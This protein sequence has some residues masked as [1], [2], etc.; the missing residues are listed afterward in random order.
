M[1]HKHKFI[2]AGFHYAEGGSSTPFSAIDVYRCRCGKS[3]DKESKIPRSKFG[4]PPRK[5]FRKKK[6]ELIVTEI[7]WER[8]ILDAID[9]A[10]NLNLQIIELGIPASVQKDLSSIVS[11][12][13]I[14]R[15]LTS[16]WGIP[17]KKTKTVTITTEVARFKQ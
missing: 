7:T 16:L 13:S 17:V 3:K 1:K 2:K 14:W 5:V 8:A 15:P 9:S 10:H 12:G 4:G 11:S 6:N